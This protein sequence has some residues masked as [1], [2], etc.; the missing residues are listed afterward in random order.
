MFEQ[1]VDET[2]SRSGL[3]VAG[4]SALLRNLLGMM[5][6]E[7]TGGVEGFAD[8]FRRAGLGDVLTSWFGGQ[9]GRPIT[10]SNLESVFGNRTLDSIAASSGLARPSVTSALVLLLPKLIGRLTPNGVLPTSSSLLS[11]VSKYVGAPAVPTLRD[12]PEARQSRMSWLP[13]AAAALLAFGLWFFLR[14]PSGTIDP[15]LTVTKRDGRVT[16]SGIVRDEAT[17]SSIVNALRATYGDANIQGDVRVDSK[18][19]PA[20]WLLRVDN[21]FAAT[22]RP[23]V[24]LALS[25]NS[26]K[27]GGWVSPAE[28]QELTARARDI[29]GSTATV[30]ALGDVAVANPRTAGVRFQKAGRPASRVLPDHLTFQN[31]PMTATV[32]FDTVT[33]CTAAPGGHVY[34]QRRT[35]RRGAA[36]VRLPLR[37]GAR[38]RGRSA[39]RGGGYRLARRLTAVRI[40]RSPMAENPK[41]NSFDGGFAR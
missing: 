26:V 9:E 18:V 31:W 17:I 13:W 4:V 27:V 38:D 12:A 30:G 20:E 24:D 23:G 37:G 25:G 15:Q 39:G 16:Y 1:L 10:P 3:P 11:Q 32:R 5:T 6:N 36:R 19:K 22:N 28:H 14:G 29:L 2:A 41:M 34:R 40:A 21:L 33:A 35:A 8:L 7:R